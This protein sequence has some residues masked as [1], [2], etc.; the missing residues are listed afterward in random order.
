MVN[1]PSHT[2]FLLFQK[3]L[4]II[5]LQVVWHICFF[6][7]GIT[8]DFVISATSFL[9]WFSGAKSFIQNSRSCLTAIAVSDDQVYKPQNIL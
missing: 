5:P 6:A 3:R 9:V 2:Y 4:A 7:E 8:G 1:K